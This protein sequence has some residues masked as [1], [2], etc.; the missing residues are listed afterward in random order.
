[1]AFQSC[2][3]CFSLRNGCIIIGVLGIFC[4]ITVV[5]GMSYTVGIID[6][7]LNVLLITGA[8]MQ[9]RLCLL[10]SIIVNVLVEFVLWILVLVSFFASFVILDSISE[11]K[12]ADEAAILN[13]LASFGTAITYIFLLYAVVHFLLLKVIC[14]HFGELREKEQRRPFLPHA[15]HSF[16][17]H[18]VDPTTSTVA[19]V[20]SD[21]VFC[22]NDG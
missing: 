10:P 15:S 5:M 12:D 1:M 2:C 21:R 3:F 17:P 7:I 22:A 11:A 4:D 18:S 20:S 8:A 19:L 13:F 14:D 9:K 6:L 16:V